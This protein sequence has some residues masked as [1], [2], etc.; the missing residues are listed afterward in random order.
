[1]RL[2]TVTWPLA[3]ALLGLGAVIGALVGP[4]ALWA[5]LV[6]A[7]AAVPFGLRRH[8]SAS[9]APP[10][11]EHAAG[12]AL[13]EPAAGLGERVQQVLRLAEEQAD[14]IRAQARREADDIVTRA[15]AH[16]EP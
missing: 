10:P 3:I 6:V 8:E 11:V 5:G 2:R 14:D 4:V 1:M 15:R 9:T 16:H 13:A 12:A 7:V